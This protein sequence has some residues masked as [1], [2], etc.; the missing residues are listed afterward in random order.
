MLVWEGPSGRQ[1]HLTGEGE[2]SL[3]LLRRNS[4]A[5][6]YTN[7]LFILHSNCTRAG[8][9]PPRVCRFSQTEDMHLE[10]LAPVRSTET[11]CLCSMNSRV[12]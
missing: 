10:D 9:A 2:S 12:P 1:P 6:V 4:S 8:H 11:A 7:A 3:E 5:A